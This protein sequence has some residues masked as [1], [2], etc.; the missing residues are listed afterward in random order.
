ME[1]RKLKC[2]CMRHSMQKKKFLEKNNTSVLSFN[3]F[4]S[5]HHH[6]QL[7]LYTVEI[8]VTD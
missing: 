4:Q 3:V 7:P 8:D 1:S 6:I 5:H 2:V